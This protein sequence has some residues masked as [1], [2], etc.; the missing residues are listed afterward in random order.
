MGIISGLCWMM[1]STS[2]GFCCSSLKYSSLCS[3]ETYL[4]NSC[5]CSGCGER[6][7]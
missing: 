6:Q 7:E 3:D 2:S 4:M 1:C 5:L